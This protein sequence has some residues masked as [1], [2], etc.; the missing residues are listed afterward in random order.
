M[1]TY[2]V[3]KHLISKVKKNPELAILDVEYLHESVMNI[4]HNKSM[5]AAEN[6]KTGNILYG[7]WV[8]PDN[9]YLFLFMVLHFK[10]LV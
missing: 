4:I 3:L 1:I 7:G 5:E 8:K 6:A 10:C 9:D 2:K